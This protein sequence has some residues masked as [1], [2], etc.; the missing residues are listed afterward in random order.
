MGKGVLTAASLMI[1]FGL[2]STKYAHASSLYGYRYDVQ[3]SSVLTDEKMAYRAS[4]L[5]PPSISRTWCEGV[6]GDGAGEWIE[7]TMTPPV[8]GKLNLAILPGYAASQQTYINNG[9]PRKL[10]VTINERIKQEV[11]IKDSL[12]EQSFGLDV[13]LNEKISH[14]R[15]KILS[16]YPGAK[17]QD[18]CITEVLLLPANVKPEGHSDEE[19]QK[20]AVNVQPLFGL[21]QS[22]KLDAI[23]GLLRLSSGNYYRTAE[24]G[25]WLDEIYLELFVKDPHRYL[26]VAL[27]QNDEIKAKA[28][29]A[30][31]SPVID[32]YTATQLL[33]SLKIAITKGIDSDSV[34]VIKDALKE[35]IGAVGN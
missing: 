27:A 20:E 30:I 32:K 35:Q 10:E 28:F 11:E 5:I 13:P 25:E 4:N 17:Y 23:E 29:D 24:G 8:R 16:V 3:A 2:T 33:D 22:G 21:A 15:L 7:L 18:T 6:E 31:I 9:R 34:E 19:L 26:Y 12:N 1:L 14:I